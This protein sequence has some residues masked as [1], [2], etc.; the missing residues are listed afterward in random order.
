MRA[1]AF[2]RLTRIIAALDWWYSSKRHD[3]FWGKVST[4]G[5]LPKWPRRWC[6]L[7]TR[8][9]VEIEW[10]DYVADASGVRCRCG[11]IDKERLWGDSKP[12]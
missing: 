2:S 11:K 3:W 10:A 9:K 7:F 12:S 6:W 5:T 8:H 1:M 4:L